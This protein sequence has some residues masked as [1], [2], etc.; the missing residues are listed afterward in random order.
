MTPPRAFIT[1][2]DGPNAYVTLDRGE[3]VLV[4]NTDMLRM[5]GDDR[6]LMAVVI[7]HE[8]GHVRGAHLTQGREIQSVIS[9]VGLMAGAV[10]DVKEARHG[11]NTGAAGAR[12]GATAATFVNAKFSRDQEREADD[13]GIRAMARAGYDPQAA[14]RLWKMMMDLGG[15][16]NGLW[17]SSHPSSTERYETLSAL[18]ASLNG[19]YTANR[20]A[21]KELPHYDDP[22][23][24]GRFPS[25]EPT[26]DEMS[27]E[28]LGPYASA[29]RLYK[30]GQLEQ[31]LPLLKV[32]ADNGDERALV[33]L[34]D[35]EQNGRLA[36]C[37][38]EDFS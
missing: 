24:K 25:M 22:Y 8:L 34:A 14:P 1:R 5:V 7:G 3:P 20:V 27:A 17:L 12:L 23:P 19:V 13:L 10:L 21:E 26:P 32:S 28:P 18:A 11:V 4:V 2:Q 15:G 33:A 31:A 9:I 37:R 30:E 38:T 35:F 6:D 29:R 36:A 16:G